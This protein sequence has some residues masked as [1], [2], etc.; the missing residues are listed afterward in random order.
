MFL[1]SI[2]LAALC[3]VAVWAQEDAAQEGAH[4]LVHKGLYTEN[5]EPYLVMNKNFTVAYT[6]INNGDVAATGVVV[7]DEWP[8]SSFTIV[9]GNA[10][11]SWAT[12]EPYVITRC[13]L[14]LP[15]LSCCFPSFPLLSVFQWPT[16]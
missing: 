3:A 7:K 5:D 2:V 4:L 12:I 15:L 16:C 14:L 11:A 6:V 9:E 10:E 8:T 13:C 1:K